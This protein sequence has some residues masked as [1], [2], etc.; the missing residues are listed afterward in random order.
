[1]LGARHAHLTDITVRLGG[2]SIIVLPLQPAAR[3]R[4]G[5]IGRNGAGKSTL[6]RVIAGNAR[7]R[8]RHSLEPRGSR[9]GDIAQEAPG[10]TATRLKPCWLAIPSVPR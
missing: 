2:R 3:G 4:I 9:I 5:L 7:A 6:V 10:G 1:M 8:W